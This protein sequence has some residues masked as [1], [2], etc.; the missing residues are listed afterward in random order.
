MRDF[1]VVIMATCFS[2]GVTQIH[3]HIVQT[4]GN[5][6]AHAVS[7]AG[8]L[9]AEIVRDGQ[10]NDKEPYNQW[11]TPDIEAIAVFE[12]RHFDK[13]GLLQRPTPEQMSQYDE[14]AGP[15][16]LRRTQGDDVPGRAGHH[17]RHQ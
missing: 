11:G 10:K 4:S 9:V 14:G 3:H 13:L 15:R 6:L 17:Q 16:A 1:T 5:N 2:E 7:G 12:G 8:A